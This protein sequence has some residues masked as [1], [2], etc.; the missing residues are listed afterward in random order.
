MTAG[1]RT[2]IESVLST[3]DS[4]RL[5][6]VRTGESS[7]GRRVGCRCARADYSRM[8][9]NAW[10]TWCT[11]YAS[12]PGGVRWMCLHLALSRPSPG[13]FSNGRGPSA[14]LHRVE[15]EVFPR[16]ISA[17]RL[18]PNGPRNRSIDQL[19]RNC[20][21][22]FCE[23]PIIISLRGARPGAFHITALRNAAI[24]DN[25]DGENN[26]GTASAYG[27]VK[28]SQKDRRIIICFSFFC[29]LRFLFFISLAKKRGRWKPAAVKS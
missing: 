22:L 3:W 24:S 18:I 6:A 8:G 14:S 2:L 15:M 10:C 26:D 13:K 29:V 7:L 27:G 28:R 12:Y 23:S 19:R 25:Y 11:T 9:A 20:T 17:A 4:A 21:C 16:R 1:E 5:A